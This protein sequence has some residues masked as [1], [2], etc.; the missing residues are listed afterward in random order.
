M[1]LSFWE[2]AIISLFRTALSTHQSWWI[3]HLRSLCLCWGRDS[4]RCLSAGDSHE[5]PGWNQHS[6][7]T[8]LKRLNQTCNTSFYAR[9]GNTCFLQPLQCWL[10]PYYMIW[11]R[12]MILPIHPTRKLW[13]WCHISAVVTVK[14]E[15]YKNHLFLL[16]LVQL[17]LQTYCL[18]QIHTGMPR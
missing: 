6:L 3:G 14:S 11:H 5:E 1:S 7:I 17:C 13:L 4:G 12:N 16:V 15:P 2:W 9:L 18:A 10:T 8:F